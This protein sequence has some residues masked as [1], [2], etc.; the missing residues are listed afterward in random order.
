L[1]QTIY[2]CGIG[3]LILGFIGFLVLVVMDNFLPW[4]FESLMN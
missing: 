1:R 3:M 4:V 2:V